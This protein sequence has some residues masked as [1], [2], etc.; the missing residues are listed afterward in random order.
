LP[1]VEKLLKEHGALRVAGGFNKT[2][3]ISGAPVGNRY[4]IIKWDDMAFLEKSYNGGVRAWIEKNAPDAVKFC[5]A[6]R[7]CSKCAVKQIVTPNVPQGRGRYDT[8]TYQT[9]AISTR[10]RGEGLQIRLL[11]GS[12]PPLYECPLLFLRAAKSHHGRQHP[13]PQRR[14]RMSRARSHQTLMDI[15]PRI[16][17]SRAAN[18]LRGANN[19]AYV[20]SW[21]SRD[22]RDRNAGRRPSSVARSGCQPGASWA[23]RSPC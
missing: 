8:A 19:N 4:V 7:P 20:V 13:R 6:S 3:T 14:V 15:R 23:R 18:G 10:T 16:L 2:V 5:C 21:S 11:A 17:G 12:T 9:G 1:E 22:Y